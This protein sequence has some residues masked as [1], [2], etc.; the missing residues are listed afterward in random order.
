MIDEISQDLA[1]LHVLELLEGEESHAFDARLA[2]EPELRAAVD[3]LQHS[4]ASLAHLSPA[5]S[6]PPALESRVRDAVLQENRH[7]PQN[8]VGTSW[9]PW[10]IAASLL[11]ACVLLA[12]DRSR[13]KSRLAELEKRNFFAE[14]QIAMLSSKLDSAP[15]ASAVIVWDA[16]KQEGVLKVNNVPATARDRDYQLWV[17]DPQYKQPVDAGV[18]GVDPSGTTRI[19]FKPKSRV[20]SAQAFAVSLERKGGVPKAEGPMVLAGK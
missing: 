11:A 12:V 9:V 7:R 3:E 20:Q 10:A 8:I 4:A 18:F 14:T 19:T 15:K 16:E 17:V 13:F 1:A 6:L 2:L 5:R